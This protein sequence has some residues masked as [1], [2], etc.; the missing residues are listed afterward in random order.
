M[1]T[2]SESTIETFGLRPRHVIA[3]TLLRDFGER[4]Q[5]DLAE[6]LRIDPTNLVGLLNDLEVGSLVERRR[7]TRDRRRHTVA[8]TPTGDARLAEIDDVLAAVEQRVLSALSES[9]QSTLYSLLRRATADGV[10]CS[11][12][13]EH[14]TA[15]CLADDPDSEQ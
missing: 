13:V 8:I 11:G 3:L 10:D 4:S 7:S 12:A 5:S 14:S 15:T 2:E 1:R 6:A 9:E